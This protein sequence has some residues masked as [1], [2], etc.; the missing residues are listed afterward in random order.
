MSKVGIM[1]ESNFYV[2]VCLKFPKKGLGTKPSNPIPLRCPAYI[3]FPR[4]PL[5]KFKNSGESFFFLLEMFW[6]PY[7]SATF[8][9]KKNMLRVCCV[10]Q[11]RC[12]AQIHIH[13]NLQELKWTIWVIKDCSCP[14]V[15]NLEKK[16][17]NKFI[18]TKIYM[19]VVCSRSWPY[20]HEIL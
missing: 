2:H 15:L 10:K 12:C 20:H 6:V 14:P 16:N 5:Q 19:Y 9:L 7:R 13:V 3:F 1:F 17:E 8:Q 4:P 11:E 18:S